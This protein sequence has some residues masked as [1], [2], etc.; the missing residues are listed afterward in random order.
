MFCVC[1]Q[2]KCECGLK[3]YDGCDGLCG[4]IVIR[5]LIIVCILLIGGIGLIGC[6]FCCQ[7]CVQGYDLVVWSCLF[8]WVVWLCVGV[9]GVVMLCELDGV[10]LFDVVIN[11]VG[12]LIVDCLWM[13]QRWKVLWCSWV[14]LIW[15]LV[16]WLSCCE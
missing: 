6:V 12:V 16:D 2:F 14:D 7:W 10:L 9:Y 1:V 11:L 4:V 8:E 13:V 5:R 15:E 3:C